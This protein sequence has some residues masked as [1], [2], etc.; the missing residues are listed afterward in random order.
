[1]GASNAGGGG[2]GVPDTIR[3]PKK[4]LSLKS[5]VMAVAKIV[6][7]KLEKASRPFNTRK[8]KEFLNKYN[9]S[10]PPG[11]RIEMTDEKIGSKEG[12][13]SL[14][15]VGYITNQDIINQNKDN[16]SLNIKQTTQVPKTIISPTKAE[17]SQSE[18]A[19]ATTVVQE[20]SIYSKKKK[21]KAKGRSSTIL[22]SSKGVTK[23]DTLTLGK[24]SLLGQV[25]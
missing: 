18:A 11:E 16:S 5:P 6:G 2:S 14:K 15:Q 3:P 8:R 21:I 17:V 10:V 24:K 25:V 13:A 9:T 19:N 1:M 4:K 7:D 12:L 20:D 22:T 23:D